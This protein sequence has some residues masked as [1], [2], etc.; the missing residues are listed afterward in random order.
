MDFFFQQIVNG[1][2]LGGSYTLI[3]L[4]LTMIYGILYIANFAH[5]PVYMFGAY[6]SYFLLTLYGFGFFQ[7][8]L[9][10]MLLVGIL[11][12]LIERVIFRPLRAA[13]HANGFIAALGL[14]FVLENVAGILWGHQ[15]RTFPV[16]YPQIVKVLSISIT[17]QRLLVIIIAVVLIGI[18]YFLIQ[19]TTLGRTIRAVAQDSHAAILVGISV[20]KIS[21]YTFAIGSALAAAAGALLGPIFL[22][23]PT[24]GSAPIIKAFVVIILGGMGSIPGAVIGGFVLGIA[25][26]LGAA[27]I[28]STFMDLYAFAILIIILTFK[29]RGLM[30]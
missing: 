6:L 14:F 7:A 24:M 30:G 20:D 2:V 27:Y 5:G 11:G 12:V 4:G 8:M 18:L 10:S 29:P 17:L 22:V 21:A 25:E 26:S 28:S 15:Y 1:L 13:P 23:Y 19:K 9:G 16:L 3:A